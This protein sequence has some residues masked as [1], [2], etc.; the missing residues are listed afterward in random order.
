MS[1]SA[2]ASALK[3]LGGAFITKN[4]GSNVAEG[5]GSG[6]HHEDVTESMAPS[7]SLAPA[8]E[9][10]EDIID[11]PDEPER[12]VPKK[13]KHNDVKPP[14]VRG[15]VTEKVVCEEEGKDSE[16]DSVHI[17]NFTLEKLASTMSEIPTDED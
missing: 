2:Y 16:G 14:K 11:I 7:T 8:I 4:P 12:P 15:P 17:S 3:N 13:R 1:S 10:F 5:S 9:N 6:A